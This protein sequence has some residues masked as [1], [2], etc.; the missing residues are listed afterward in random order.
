MPDLI[1]IKFLIPTEEIQTYVLTCKQ[2]WGFIHIKLIS[3][4][5]NSASSVISMLKALYECYTQCL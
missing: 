4:F 1:V 5:P 3:S 2:L